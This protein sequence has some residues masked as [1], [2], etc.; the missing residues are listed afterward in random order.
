M[1]NATN[2]YKSLT[3]LDIIL[4]GAAGCVFIFLA[5]RTVAFTEYQRR[6]WNNASRN[7]CRF[8]WVQYVLHEKARVALRI[9]N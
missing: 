1:F 2:I 3:G 8:S 5:P 7:P 6:A 4:I 9:S